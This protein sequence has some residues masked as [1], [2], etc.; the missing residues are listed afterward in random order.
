MNAQQLA[1]QQKMLAEQE[2]SSSFMKQLN[3]KIKASK[4]KTKINTHKMEW[5]K[6]FTNLKKQQTEL[7]ES[8]NE[9]VLTK[10]KGK[11]EAWGGELRSIG[12]KE[13]DEKAIREEFEQSLMFP[14]RGARQLLLQ[15]KS[16][17]KNAKSGNA[18]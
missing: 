2:R 5:I 13:F 6:K 16:D 11:E 1:F 9:F 15:T 14:V 18:A 12:T 10:S 8:L 3:G 4:A 17:F 7:E